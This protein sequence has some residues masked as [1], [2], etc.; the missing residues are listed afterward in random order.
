MTT[1]SP[2]CQAAAEVGQGVEPDSVHD[3]GGVPKVCGPPESGGEVVHGAVLGQGE[4]LDAQV[5]R[6]GVSMAAE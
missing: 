2:S 6:P 4:E 3:D 5:P 1:Q